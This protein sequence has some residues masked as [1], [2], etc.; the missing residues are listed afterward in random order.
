[1][2]HTPLLNLSWHW[3]LPVRHIPVNPRLAY[4]IYGLE[5]VVSVLFSN[6]R[7]CLLYKE[8]EIFNTALSFASCS[9]ENFLFIVRYARACIL[10]QNTNIIVS[11]PFNIQFEFTV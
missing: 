11:N 1:M 5:N 10:K 6:T 2:V 9:I 7:T 8:L 4:V 3:L